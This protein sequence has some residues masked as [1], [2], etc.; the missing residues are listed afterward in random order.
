MENTMATT[1]AQMTTEELKELIGAIIEQKLLELFG[2]PDEGLVMT[3]TLRSRLLRQKKAT[4]KGERGELFE[5]VVTRLG[6]A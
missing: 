6:L 3:K 1:V 5:D 4:A 2:D